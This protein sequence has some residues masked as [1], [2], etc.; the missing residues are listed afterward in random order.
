M[1]R[2]VGGD[3]WWVVIGKVHKMGKIV[4]WNL[5]LFSFPRLGLRVLIG[6]RKFILPRDAA[7]V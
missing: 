4:M 1:R 6:T 3:V 7:R 5:A 2:L